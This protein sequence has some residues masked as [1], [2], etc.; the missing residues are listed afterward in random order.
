[1]IEAMLQGR[2]TRVELHHVRLAFSED[3]ES[4]GRFAFRKVWI[5]FT[6]VLA[7]MTARFRHRTPVLYYPPAGPNTVPVVRDIILLCATRWLF[8][9]TVFH[10]H[11]GGVSGFASSLPTILRPFFRWAYGRPAVAIRTA[12]Q[13]PDD[14]T[15]LRARH[16]VVV[17]NGLPDMRGRVPERTAASGEPLT[18]LFTGVLIPSK[19]LRVMLEAFALAVSRGANLRLEL[20]G[21]WGD[22]GFR[23]ACE[24]FIRAHELQDRVRALGVLRDLEKFDRFASC[25][26]FCFPSHFEAESFGLVLVEAMM[27]AKPVISTRWRGIPSVVNDGVNGFLVDTKDPAAVAD[28]LVT[29][30]GDPELRQRMGQEGR[31]IFEQRFTLERFHRS[32]E[33]ALLLAVQTDG[34]ERTR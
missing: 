2:Y 31:R 3:M 21:K 27:F 18:V 23:N 20:M 16:N 8:R 11:A 6:T 25:D 9:A 30:A 33:E 19:G 14:G 22:T 26:I 32:M 7:V 5:L 12:A 4:V 15:V 10:F 24:D 34:S 28:R 13:N 29:L 1:M 17:P